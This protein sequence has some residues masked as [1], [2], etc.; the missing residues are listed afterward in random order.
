MGVILKEPLDIVVEVEDMELPHRHR[1]AVEVARCA[2]LM[3]GFAAFDAAVERHP[4]DRVRLRQGIMTIRDTH[5]D[6]REDLAGR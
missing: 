3:I 6:A 4:R 5:R 2:A 1:Q